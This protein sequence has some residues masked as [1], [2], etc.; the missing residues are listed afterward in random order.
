MNLGSTFRISLKKLMIFIDM[1]LDLREDRGEREN[2]IGRAH[3]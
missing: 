1:L 3:V 2:Q